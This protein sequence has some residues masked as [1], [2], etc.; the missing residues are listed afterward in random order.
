MGDG[1]GVGVGAADTAAGEGD[2][3]A[4]LLRGGRSPEDCG[5]R[6]IVTLLLKKLKRGTRPFKRR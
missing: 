1:V 5:H 6:G 2:T 4:G 3:A